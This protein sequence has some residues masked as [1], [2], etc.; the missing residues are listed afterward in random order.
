MSGFSFPAADSHAPRRRSHHRSRRWL[1]LLPAS[2]LLHLFVLK[3]ADGRLGMPAWQDEQPTVM[4]TELLPPPKPVIAPPAPRPKPAPRP[5]KRAAPKPPEPAPSIPPAAST[6]KAPPLPAGVP[7]VPDGDPAPVVAEPAAEA[8]IVPPSAAAGEPAAVPSEA[9]TRYKFDPPPSAQ[10]EY[11]V[12]GLRDEQKWYGSGKF[13]WVVNGDSYSVSAEA[14]IT[15][16]FKITVLNFRS[17]GRI[18]DYGVSPVLYSEKPFRKSMTNTHFR[19]DK[20]LIS[21]SAS[22]ATYPWHGGAQDRASVIWQLASIGRGDPDRFAPGA[23][24][25]LFVAGTRDAE[26]WQIQVIGAEEIETGYGKLQ[27]WHVARMPR[28]GSYD[29]RIDIWLAPQQQWYPAMVR[30]TYP[31][32]D[33][34]ELSLAEL[35]PVATSPPSE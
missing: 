33:Y 27:A 25:D 24:I 16:L 6:Y 21:F 11:D 34:I 3:W 5:V 31:N 8:D 9:E 35:R 28:P 4:T 29:Q 18:D 7:D 22:E 12:T 10:L 30:Y 14:S 13:D 15:I 32:K 26:T 17:E 19:R 20:Q 23:T 1:L 2:L